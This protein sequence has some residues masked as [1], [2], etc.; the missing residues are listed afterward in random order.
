MRATFVEPLSGSFLVPSR[1]TTKHRPA[2]TGGGVAWVDDPSAGLALLL[3][4][5]FCPLGVS[6]QP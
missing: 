6:D 2:A 3:V 1:H 4:A 5:N